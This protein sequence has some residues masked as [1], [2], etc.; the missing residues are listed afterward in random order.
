MLEAETLVT[1]QQQAA[2]DG[3]E[4]L[5]LD[6]RTEGPGDV[7]RGRVGLLCAEAALLDREVGPVPC[8]VDVVDALDAAV[9]IDR[10]EAV[11]VGGEARQPR[12]LQHRQ[13]HD[14]VRLQELVSGLEGDVAVVGLVG[15]PAGDDA[16]APG[17]EYSCDLGAAGGSECD[18]GRGLGGDEADLHGHPR[19]PRVGL[20]QQG[21]L[22]EGEGPG[23]LGRNDKGDRA[24]RARGVPGEQIG[25][26]QSVAR[27]LEGAGV[28]EGLGGRGAHADD[29]AVVWDP[30]SVA[31]GDGVARRVDSGD[32]PPHELAADLLDGSSEISLLRRLM[33]ERLFD[34]QGLVGE[35]RA[36]SDED[37]RSSVTG[38][39]A[40]R[41]QRLKTGDPAA[42]DDDAG[43]LALALSRG[44][45]PDLLSSSPQASPGL[46]AR[47][48][49]S[50]AS[51]L[52]AGN[53]GTPGLR[54][55]PLVKGGGEP[56]VEPEEPLVPVELPQGKVSPLR[57]IVQRLLVALAMIVFVALLAYFGRDGYV[58][59]EDDSISLLDAFYYSTVSV[60][61]TGYG[62]IRP[63]S[64]EA[65]LTTTLLVTPA[66]ILF[67][68]ILVGTT[69]EILAERTRTAY[70]LRRWRASLRDHIIVCGFGTKGQ[71]AVRTLLSKGEDRNRIV[72]IDPAQDARARAHAAGL[73]VVDGR[74]V[75]Q[76]VLEEACVGEAQTV[77][78]AVDS[79]DAAVL[80]TLT[81]RELARDA[82]IVVAV[83]E[84]EN[85]HLLHQSG[86][87]SVVTSSGA[88]GRLLGLATDS[89][90]ITEVLEDLLTVGE[91][92]EIDEVRIT[93]EEAGDLS[94]LD[95]P[96]PVLAIV[97]DGQLL[98]FDDEG[99]HQ[100]R[101]GD[102]VVVVSSHPRPRPPARALA[103]EPTGTS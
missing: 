87:N 93:R 66:R 74:A 103:E 98:R 89:P 62:D 22:I 73:A 49:L 4:R 1:D 34:Y 72:V 59:P 94:A 28:A 76:E 57:K 46:D 43:R 25:K 100:A 99:A 79:D 24:A 30:R 32:V 40:D 88:A 53:A 67:L 18:Q 27:V 3:M 47:S 90:G 31:K 23:R 101:E 95:L 75:S 55:L 82:K 86:A 35:V 83:R 33:G 60:T 26:S 13:G 69:L 78:V 10:Q 92:L 51:R 14:V 58:D 85:V 77:I 8:R 15:V 29:Q 44:F 80:T 6:V 84:E 2:K 70:R 65:R 12:A 9:L 36:R 39:I 41:Q 45:D 17:L 38:E 19:L 97:R 52:Q 61:T 11:L 42:R 37:R 21:E 102:R 50:G 16:D 64:D 48:N 91:G 81:A 96:G 5:R 7:L 56:A 68:I 54:T 20:G 63:V 71:T